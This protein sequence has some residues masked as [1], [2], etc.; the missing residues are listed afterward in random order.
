MSRLSLPLTQIIHENLSI[1]MAFT[2]SR[3]PLEQLVQTRFPGEWKYLEK[4]PFSILEQRSLKACIELATFMRL[5]DD[6]ENFS[7]FLRKVSGHSF[8]SVI[9]EGK[10]DERLYLRDL[11]NKI[12]HASNLEWNFSDP[13]EPKLICIS[14]DPDRWV[15]AEIHVVALAAFCGRL[16]S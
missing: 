14:P 9:K 7:G 12:M 1:I 2:F 8:G 10:P 6:Q 16:M 3:R 5:L 4:A 13:D 15:R 11:T